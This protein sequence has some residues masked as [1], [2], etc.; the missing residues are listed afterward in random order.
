MRNS[1]RR[2]QLAPGHPKR[3][4]ADHPAYTLLETG[5]ALAKVDRWPLEAE[6]FHQATLARPDYAEAWA[7]WGE[8][9]QHPDGADDAADTCSPAKSDGL[10][11]AAE[12]RVTRPKSLT[13][14][15]FLPST[16]S[17]RDV[18]TRPWNLSRPALQL[19]P[20]NPILVAELAA[21]QAP[22]DNLDEATRPTS[23]W[24]PFPHLTR[25]I[26]ASR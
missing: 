14:Q 6:A 13:A 4:F 21:V 1:N 20:D 7:Y 2:L 18:M 25:S 22:S 15:T 24:L 26:C 9:L 3:R 17:A 5:R 10:G 12:S 19:A 8:A 23:R 16:G 11:R